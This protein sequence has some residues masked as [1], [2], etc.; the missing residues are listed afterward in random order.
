MRNAYYFCVKMNQDD[1]YTIGYVRRVIGVKGEMGILLDVDSPARYKGLDAM[2]LV[3]D[4]KQDA[5]EL[6]QAVVRGEELVIRIKGTTTPE[7]AK[8]FVGSTCML[9]LAALPKLNDKQFYFHEIPG[10]KVVDAVCGEIGIAKEVMDR[11]QQ[12]V[13]IIKHGFEEVLIPIAGDIVQKV[14]RK[15][16]VLHIHAPEGLIELYLKKPDEEE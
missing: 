6:E 9:P 12:P 2:L 14:D 3:K 1:F 8:K 13:L 5:V 4:G 10:Y 11:P 7:D 15:E 16:K